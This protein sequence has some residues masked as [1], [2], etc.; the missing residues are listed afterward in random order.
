[1]YGLTHSLS[2]SSLF[3]FLSIQKSSLSLSLSVLSVPWFI[4]I[5]TEEGRRRKEV[6]EKSFQ[7]ITRSFLF[8]SAKKKKKKR[9]CRSDKEKRGFFSLYH[10]EKERER[11]GTNDKSHKENTEAV[12]CEQFDWASRYK[13]ALWATRAAKVAGSAGG[14]D[15]AAS[16]SALR[17]RQYPALRESRQRM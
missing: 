13:L 10:K 11:N 1:M 9:V 8:S 7:F 17:W 16:F 5:S 4:H 2:I 3:P 6:I 15:R 12:Y 14:I